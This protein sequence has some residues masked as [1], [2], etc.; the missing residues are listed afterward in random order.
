MSRTFLGR[1]QHFINMFNFNNLTCL[2]YADES[3]GTRLISYINA[4]YV[5]L[6]HPF[7][8]CGTGNFLRAITLQSLKSPVPYT[9]EYAR[10]MAKP[11]YVPTNVNILYVL[12]AELGFIAT[13]V[14][15]AFFISLIITINKKLKYASG[16]FKD[17]I[18]GFYF[19]LIIYIFLTSYESL[20]SYFWIEWGILLGILYLHDKQKGFIIE[21]INS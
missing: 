7:I 12:L 16:L 8:G 17:F 15:Y 6:S 9:A 21:N 4:F 18:Q 11:G 20:I 3:L 10:R 5:F 1:I 2:I 14:Y 19:M 13:L